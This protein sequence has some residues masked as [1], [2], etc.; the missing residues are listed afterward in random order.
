MKSTLSQDTGNSPS[1]KRAN[2]N[3]PVNNNGDFNMN[4]VMSS[5]SSG[6]LGKGLSSGASMP[7]IDSGASGSNDLKL[8]E[9]NS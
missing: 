7:P 3:E 1:N 8:D 9:A 2:S 6:G 4:S 5:A